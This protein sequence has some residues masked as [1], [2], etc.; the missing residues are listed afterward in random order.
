MD[1]MQAVSDY[2]AERYLLGEMSAT[3]VEEFERH[4][5][6]CEACAM[7]VEAAQVFVA[8]ASSVL[9]EGAP[10]VARPEV[11]R[12]EAARPEAARKDAPAAPRQSMWEAVMAWRTNPAFA[13]TA[14]TA[15]VLG[16]LAVYQGAVQIPGL[17]RNLEEVRILPSF[18]LVGTSRGEPARI[19]VPSGTPS[20]SLSADIPPDVHFPGYLCDLSAGGR[21]LFSLPARVP[22]PGQPITILIPA[23]RL[24][25]GTYELGIY[26][27][28]AG[29]HKQDRVTASAFVLEFR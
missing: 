16:A 24:P 27:A 21:T 29:G 8:N 2:S 11:A 25:A 23:K 10:E 28:D 9:S 4:Y 13:F 12:P 26:G 5:F 6:E 20:F 7:A 14:T 17:R 19:T 1:H 3:E 18:Q 15:L 22:A